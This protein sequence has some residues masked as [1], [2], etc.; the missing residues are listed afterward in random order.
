MDGPNHNTHTFH[1]DHRLEGPLED[2]SGSLRHSVIPELR[3]MCI[4]TELL[5][6]NL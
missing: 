5:Q 6:T 4:R 1:S 2:F 3:G